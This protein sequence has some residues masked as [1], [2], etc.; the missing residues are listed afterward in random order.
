MGGAGAAAGSGGTGGSKGTGGNAG[1][2]G[3]GGVGGRGGVGGTGTTTGQVF[4]ENTA[5][6]SVTGLAVTSFS[7]T[8]TLLV[9]VSIPDAPSGTTFKFT[10]TTGLTASYGFTFSDSMTT[11]NFSGTKAAV[12][13]ALTSMQLS[14]GTYQ[15]AFNFDVTSTLNAANTYYNPLNNN[16]YQ[17]VAGNV[18]WNT[19][20]TGAQAQSYNGATGYLVTITNASENDFVK[21]KVNATNIWIGGSDSGVEGVWKWVTGPEAGTQFWQGASAASGG[22]TTAPYFYASWANG[23]PNNSSGVEHY[24]VTNWR[25]TLGLWNDLRNRPAETINGYLVEYS[26]PVG[27]WTGAQQQYTTAYVGGADGGVGG[28]G[29]VGG[30][31]GNGAAGGANGGTATVG[32]NGGVGGV[33]GVG[34]SGSVRNGG[35]G[36]IGGAGGTGGTS[37]TGNAGTAGS[38]GG[39]GTD[40]TGT[41]GGTGGVGG[42]GGTGGI[43]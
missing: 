14:T 29:G 39:A 43:L 16:Y 8:D 1:A 33:G 24:A 34:G 7:D 32:G 38:A 10:S 15:G 42:D 17:Y 25:G 19:A 5:N 37:G 41:P 23:E 6:Q 2:A 35:A 21:S 12:N 40:A 36:G 22:V 28:A 3:V 13:A 11:I 31:G 20:S 18:D 26:E 27:G 30:Q 4:A 9:S